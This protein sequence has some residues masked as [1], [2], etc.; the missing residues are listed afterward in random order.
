MVSLLDGRDGCVPLS[1]CPDHQL[2]IIPIYSDPAV[3][4]QQDSGRQQDQD[5]QEQSD[6][7]G[8]DRIGPDAATAREARLEA[9]M[10]QK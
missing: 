8:S 7:S 2:T 6:A 1:L 9:L 10:A 3:A 5:Q 4:E